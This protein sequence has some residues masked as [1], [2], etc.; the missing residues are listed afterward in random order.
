MYCIYIVKVEMEE[1]LKNEM[2]VL[3][4]TNTIKSRTVETFS[5]T[6]LFHSSVFDTKKLRHVKLGM[7]STSK[8]LVDPKQIYSRRK[9]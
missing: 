4:A 1:K 3:I 5:D 6:G 9:E 2:N 7:K 8:C